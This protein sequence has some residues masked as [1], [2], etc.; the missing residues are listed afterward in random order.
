MDHR[1]WFVLAV[2]TSFAVGVCAGQPEQN[3]ESVVA[4]A[5]TLT[6]SNCDSEDDDPALPEYKSCTEGIALLE[7]VLRSDPENL[8]AM[9][10]LLHAIPNRSQSRALE[11][12]RRTLELDPG[13]FDAIFFLGRRAEGVEDRMSSLQAAAKLKAEHP[14]V[15][16]F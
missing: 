5:E 3:R 4:R 6:R 14:S 16:R 8:R 12:A 9:L 15:R 7:E 11:I 1:T 10:V 2:V 13:N